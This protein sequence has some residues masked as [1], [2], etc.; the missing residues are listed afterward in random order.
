MSLSHLTIAVVLVSLGLA[1][2]LAPAQEPRKDQDARAKKFV[3]YYEATVRPLE[4]EAARLYWTANVTGKE[5]DFERKEAAEGKVDDCLSDPE[6]FAEL[7]A[8]KQGPVSDLRLA[9]EIA[10]LYLEYLGKQVDP[11]L[12][13]K[14]RVKSNAVERAFNVFRPKVDG[15]ELTDND[16]RRVLRQSHDSAERRAVWEASKKVGPE[17]AGDLRELVARATRLPTSWASRTTRC[18][19]S[20]AANRIRSRSSNCSTNLTHLHGSRSTRRK[21]RSTPPWQRIVAL[22]SPSCGRGIITIRFSRR[23]RPSWAICPN[24]STNRS[25]R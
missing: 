19:N 15:H 13:Q 22:R 8:I 3:E 2:G 7:K 21:P 1:V 11:K 14:M 6:R 18:C 10:V 17:V 24:R 5:E 25:I 12:L 16:V 23:L 20:I 9:R 4:I